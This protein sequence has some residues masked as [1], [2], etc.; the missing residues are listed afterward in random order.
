[1]VYEKPR[2]RLSTIPKDH[3][4]KCPMLCIDATDRCRQCYARTVKKVERIEDKETYI[5]LRFDEEEPSGA[6]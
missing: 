1:M 6:C 4:L 3:G 2:N 5:M